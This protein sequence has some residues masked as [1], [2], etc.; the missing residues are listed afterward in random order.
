MRI[1][2]VFD[3]WDTGVFTLNNNRS[4]FADGNDV[5]STG[6]EIPGGCN[7]KG[8]NMKST[9]AEGLPGV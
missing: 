3:D 6:I 8:T 1:R 9:E 4:F 7:R 2:I 5:I